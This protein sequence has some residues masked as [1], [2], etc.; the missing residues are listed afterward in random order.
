MA[1]ILFYTHNDL[2][3]VGCGI[4]AKLAYGDQAEV[5]YLNNSEVDDV[6]EQIISQQDEITS[7][8]KILFTDLS[9]SA[10]ALMR[11]NQYFPNQIIVIDHHKSNLFAST[12]L[13][14]NGIVEADKDAEGK[15]QSGTSLVYRYI[16]NENS[17]FRNNKLVEQF[18][19][20]VR[21]Y[22][23]YQW[24]ETD[25]ILPKQLQTLF[26]ILENDI[27]EKKF[28]KRLSDSK[29]KK[30]IRDQEMEFVDSRINQEIESINKIIDNPKNFE[31]A[32][33]KGYKI[34]IMYYPG[35]MNISELGYRFL[36]KYPLFDMILVVNMFYNTYN[37]RTREADGT[38]FAI[39]LGGGG[40]P[41]ACGCSIPKEISTMVA[42][43]IVESLMFEII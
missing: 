22:D 16:V 3:G 35:G 14:E 12:I 21:S 2:D 30:L 28:L 43:S 13:G 27:F 29:S 36:E 26:S 37:F 39:P 24:K 19:E 34:A 5:S 18:V 10:S 17:S 6:V 42:K 40:H 25:D 41:R 4:L 7:D 15:L 31:E 1:K 8:I 33:V 32:N 20:A 23:T 9:P 11:L 38:V